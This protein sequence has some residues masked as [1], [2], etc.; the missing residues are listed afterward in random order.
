M[1]LIILTRSKLNTANV[2]GRQTTVIKTCTHHCA[3]LFLLFGE[4]VEEE[5]EEEDQ[6]E[7]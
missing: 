6:V 2:P 4:E 5:K 7:T 3:V 1:C